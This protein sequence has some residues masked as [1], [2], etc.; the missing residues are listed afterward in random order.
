M[1]FLVKPEEYGQE[2]AGNYQVKVISWKEG[3][4]LLRKAIRAKDPTDYIEELVA[5]T[6][7]G[8]DNS[9]ISREKQLTLPSGLMRRLMDETLRVNDISRPEALFLQT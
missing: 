4:E 2:Y 6:C 9:L 8:P 1:I 5:A 7:S 3:R